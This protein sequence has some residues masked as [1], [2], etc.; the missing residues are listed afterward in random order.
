M[1]K[2]SAA[3]VHLKFQRA[4]DHAS[5]LER[6]VREFI[7]STPFEVYE[8]EERATGD[9]I[10]R[11]RVRRQPPTDLSI[12][13]GDVVHNARTALDHLA[14]QL[15][16]ANDAQPTD[17][18]MFPIGKSREAFPSYAKACLKGVSKEAFK[19]VE[20]LKPYQGEDERFWRLHRLAIED[21]HHLLVPVGASHRNIVMTMSFHGNEHLAPF[22]FPPIALNPANHQYPLQDGAEIFRVMQAARTGQE[23]FHTEHAFTFEVAFGDGASA[24]EPL[25]PTLANLVEEISQAVEPLV[26]MLG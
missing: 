3:G 21:K 2:S 1:S 13:I 18:T 9:L 26:S 5:E 19:V 23:L 7:E 12:T 14:W 10:T 17:K 20:G 16:L 8:E 24:G 4:R 15:V 22:K 11:V 25:I 6:R